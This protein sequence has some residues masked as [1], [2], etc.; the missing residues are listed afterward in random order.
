MAKVW[1]SEVGGTIP[2]GGGGA[3][4]SGD[5]AHIF[6]YIYMYIYYVCVYVCIYTMCV[7]IYM[8]VCMYGMVWYGMVWYGVVRYGMVWYGMVCMYACMHACM[9]VCMYR[10]I[11]IT[12]YVSYIYIATACD[13]PILRL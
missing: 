6:I 4:Q 7:Y 3:W 12:L 2:L 10:N 1:G 13:L 11:I 9:H 5:Q 8:Y